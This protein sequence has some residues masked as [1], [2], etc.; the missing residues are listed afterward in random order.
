MKKTALLLLSLALAIVFI[1][2]GSKHG[3]MKEESALT[4]LGLIPKP[5]KLERAAGSFTIVPETK[6][7]VDAGN[8]DT[9][10]VGAYV[11]QELGRSTGYPFT[12]E[13]TRAGTAI[14]GG[15]VLTM[16]PAAHGDPRD[17]S[18]E[19]SVTGEGIRISAPRAAGLFYG[20]QTLRQL[21]PPQAYAP[22]KAANVSWVVP[23]VRIEDRPRFAWRGM[24][25][26]V[27]RHF[28]PKSFVKE[29]I[30]IAAMHK[31]NIFHWHLTDDQ[32]W[33]VEIKRYP[34]LTSVGAWR[35]DRE[36]FTW[37]QRKPAGPG[38][39][40][41]YG[42]FYTQDD[43]REVVAYAKS[44]FVTIV[45]EIEMPG[46][47]M[48]ALA[49]YP[50][51]SCTGGPFTVRT[52]GYWPITDIFCAGNDSTF[53][54]IQNIL[55]EVVELF[56]GEFFHIGGDE[57]N[58]ANWKKCPKCQARIAREHLKDEEELQSYFIRRIEKFLNAKGKR[59]IGWDEI[60]QGGLA[61]NATVMSWRGIDGG[62][63]AARENHDVVMTPTSNC[64]FDYY[65]AMSGEPE[66]IGGY[67][68]LEKVYA[69]EPVP[70]VLNPTEAKHVLGVQA[71]L[72]TEYVPYARHAE[73]M[74]LPRLSALAEVAWC[75]PEQ[76]NY[77]GFLARLT[78]QFARYDQL[79]VNYRLTAP[80]F[81]PNGGHVL[82]D[83]QKEIEVTLRNI[84]PGQ[85]HYALDGSDPSAQ[86]PLFAGPL[87]L[88]RSATL[89]ARTVAPWGKE[90]PVAAA[91]FSFVDPA[92]NGIEYAYYE[93]EWNTLPDFDA[94]RP[95]RT[96]R[97]Y[98]LGLS[99]I[100]PRDDHFAVRFTS[101]I[102]V[103]ADGAY[104]FFT[105]S[106]DGSSLF[107]DGTKVVDND[108]PH[109]D[110]EASGAVPLKAGRHSLVLLYFQGIG[111]RMLEVSYQGPGIEKQVI[112]GSMLFRK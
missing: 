5:L 18:Y 67:L 21:L 111:G 84:V 97:V 82:T 6:I 48:A 72:W 102:D 40:A 98:E 99:D 39:V 106:D 16:V 80:E 101:L 63:A 46:H 32:G 31:L 100:K 10:A 103:P 76:K 38:E 23:A 42:G 104:T 28:F 55:S 95:L 25:L 105:R 51:F 2:C 112:P 12:L 75:S 45:P 17:E 33:R 9:R 73:Y 37:N 109:G 11:Q 43:I 36:Q 59:L 89:K 15:I 26:D 47:A 7:F 50:E 35:V 49:G 56:P 96:G 30:D 57:A 24:M 52:G 91:V 70:E 22:Q 68:P 90:S 3:I 88:Q 58:K 83:S 79:G 110:Q 20:V 14:P 19:L 4:E 44:R 66:G 74:L 86:S 60:L 93:G 108:G 61:P 65:Q 107:I 41:T 81:T 62:I 53:T 77:E 1:D 94:L 71:N 54:F 13:E 8:V 92:V 78:K 87:V 69:Y 34:K 85:V 29:C 27:S 64:Y